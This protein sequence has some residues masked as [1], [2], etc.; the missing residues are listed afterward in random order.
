MSVNNTT[1][2]ISYTGDG[3]SVIFTVPFTWYDQT[4]LQV[5]LTVPGNAPTILVLNKDYT[6]T[7]GEPNGGSI[8]TTVAPPVG[9]ALLIVRNQVP[10]TQL[11][12]LITNGQF[13]AASIEQALD[14]LTM[15]CQQL[16]ALTG[17]GKSIQFPT[18]DSPTLNSILPIAAQRAGLI[19]AFDSYG[20]VIA[21]E[22]PG[23]IT[24]FRAYTYE[25]T[26][27][28]GTTAQLNGQIQIPT[29]FAKRII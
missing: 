11:L 5:T 19:C 6:V 14:Q 10:L 21:I 22:P 1:S 20:N 17:N 8:T 13:P 4:W 16:F 12:D 15:I 24:E 26:D 3:Q 23:P 28:T 25:A 27:V 29:N 9:S 7:G 18:T 2:Q